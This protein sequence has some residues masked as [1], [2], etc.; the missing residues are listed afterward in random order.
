MNDTDTIV[1]QSIIGNEPP[2]IDAGMKRQFIEGKLQSLKKERPDWFN[3]SDLLGERPI[4]GF[5]RQLDQR[6]LDIRIHNSLQTRQLTG[7]EDFY[8][9]NKAIKGPESSWQMD[10]NAV[11]P[12]RVM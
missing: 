10:P 7:Q 3:Y 9:Q 4:D 5:I 6:L 11:K 12:G 1:P 8:Q 2:P